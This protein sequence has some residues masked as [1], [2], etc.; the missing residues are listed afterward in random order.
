MG[1]STVYL[2]TGW[3]QAATTKL[4]RHLDKAVNVEMATSTDC[5]GFLRELF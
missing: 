2:S 5:F 1:G 3:Q 4:F